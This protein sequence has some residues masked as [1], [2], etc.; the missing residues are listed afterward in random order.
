MVR[1]RG[2]DTRP[3]LAL[4]S[5]LHRMGLRFRLH[6]PVIPGVR[7][8]VDIVFPG[9]RV[10]VFVDG[11]YWHGCPVHGT[12]PKANAEWWQRKLAENRRRDADS[13]RRLAEE[14]WE[15]VRVW[16]HDDPATTA[17]QIA[18]HVRARNPGT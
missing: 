18:T 3:E 5:A 10:A 14:G 7:R 15:V 17:R 11:C 12:Q 1:Q 16:E 4:R 13:N 8:R 9:A 6:A 2:T